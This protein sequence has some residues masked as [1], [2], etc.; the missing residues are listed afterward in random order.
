MKDIL[1]RADVIKT[2]S[3]MQLVPW[4]MTPEQY[5]GWIREDIEKWGRVTVA[6]KF[7]PE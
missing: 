2:M 5:T 3:D 4:Y 1:N 6:I 7:Q